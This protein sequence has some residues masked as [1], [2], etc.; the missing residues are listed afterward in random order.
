MTKQVYARLDDNRIKQL[1]AE[2]KK[3]NVSRAQIVTEA[4]DI[5]LDTKV[6]LKQEIDELREARNAAQNQRDKFKE[7]YEKAVQTNEVLLTKIRELQGQGLFRRASG[8][9][10]INLDTYSISGGS[11]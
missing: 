3:K 2:C 10:Q 7:K 9:K 8:V 5:Y 4:V 1:E 6:N 11:K